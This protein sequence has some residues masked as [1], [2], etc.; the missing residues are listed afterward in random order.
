MPIKNIGIINLNSIW[1]LIILVVE[2]KPKLG[3]RKEYIAKIIE[4]IPNIRYRYCSERNFTIDDPKT[5]PGVPNYNIC[6]KI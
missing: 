2:Y 1:E 5:T 6:H 3:L 4:K